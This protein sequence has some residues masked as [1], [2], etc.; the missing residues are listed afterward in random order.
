MQERLEQ[1]KDLLA[2]DRA[3]LTSGQFST[4]N[5]RSSAMDEIVSELETEQYLADETNAHLL[6]EIL[7]LANRNS[8]LLLAGIEGTK[9]AREKIEMIR[10]ATSQLNTYSRDGKV[11]DVKPIF[12]DAA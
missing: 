1:L 11:E 5:V 6:K 2:E 8:S 9:A 7:S 10:R 12:T 3:A 4:L